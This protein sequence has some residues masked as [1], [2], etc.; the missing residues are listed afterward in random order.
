MLMFKKS[1]ILF[2]AA[3]MTIGIIQPSH[4]SAAEQIDENSSMET[5][6]KALKP[7]IDVSDD[8]NVKFDVVK[9]EENG[10]S[11]FIIESGKLINEFN[12]LY[13]EEAGEISTFGLP[14]WGNWCGP[15]YGG[16]PTK[17]YLD[18]ACKAHDL[19]YAKH[20]YFDCNSDK[21]LIARIIR[22]YN[23]MGFFEKRAAT[24]VSAYFTAQLTV[25]GCNK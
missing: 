15:K 6:Q 22:D 16:G 4:S 10:E 8:G 19:D 17:D 20:G 11:D 21:R 2:I 18:A 13:S 1:F 12:D 5:V 14:L 23:K 3:L 9:A 7:Y 25:N 24:A